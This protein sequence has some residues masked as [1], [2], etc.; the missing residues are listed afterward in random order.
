MILTGTVAPSQGWWKALCADPPEHW[1]SIVI[2]AKAFSWPET[3]RVNPLARKFPK[4][5]K[6]LRAKFKHARKN[7]D[8]EAVYRTDQLNMVDQAPDTV[9]FTASEWAQVLAKPVPDREGLAVVGLDLSRGRSWSCCAGI[10]QSGLTVVKAFAGG[11]P[12]IHLQEKRDSQRAGSYKKLVEDGALH[13]HEN[14]RIPDHDAMMDLVHSWNPVACAADRF[15]QDTAADIAGDV[16]TEYRVKRWSEASADIQATREFFLDG[17]G[18]LSEESKRIVTFALSQSV[19]KVESDG[20]RRLEKHNP[21]KSRNDP[22]VALV[23]AAGCWSRNTKTMQ[24]DFM[25]SFI[26]E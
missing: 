26:V 13:L 1:L 6:E 7:A 3:L 17:P 2:Q 14:R 4:T 12:E 5:R 9:L 18:C 11:V 20:F 23:M 25:E 10:W 8:A 15:F 16:P 22:V 24:E 19:V 21:L